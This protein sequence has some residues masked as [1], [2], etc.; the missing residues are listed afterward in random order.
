MNVCI[1]IFIYVYSYSMYVQQQDS[2][3]FTFIWAIQGRQWFQKDEDHPQ[4]SGSSVYHFFGL[5]CLRLHRWNRVRVSRG[6]EK[7]KLIWWMNLFIRTRKIEIDRIA[8]GTFI[9]TQSLLAPSRSRSRLEIRSTHVLWFV[10]VRLHPFEFFSTFSLCSVVLFFCFRVWLSFFYCRVTSCWS[11]TSSMTKEPELI[12]IRK[13]LKS[14]VGWDMGDLGMIV[15]LHRNLGMLFEKNVADVAAALR[16]ISQSTNAK[17]RRVNRN[18]MYWY[19]C[20]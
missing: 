9:P 7:S 12:F 10:A 3:V 6:R 14:L 13:A 19:S 4:S 16:K 15:H 1:Y 5:Q 18:E 20:R 8:S 2:L 17:Q 11:A